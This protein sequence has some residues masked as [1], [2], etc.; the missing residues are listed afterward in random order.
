MPVKQFDGHICPR[1]HNLVGTG[2]CFC[3]TRHSFCHFWMSRL[4]MLLPFCSEPNRP[5]MDVVEE[6]Q[7]DIYE[8]LLPNY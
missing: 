4:E 2:E 1:S 7:G 5:I 8:L 3:K 6:L